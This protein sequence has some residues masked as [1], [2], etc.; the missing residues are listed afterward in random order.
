MLLVKA[1]KILLAPGLSL[2]ELDQAQEYMKSFLVGFEAVYP[3]KFL[4]TANSHNALHLRETILDHSA[5]P[6]HWLF[7]FERYNQDI[8]GFRTYRKGCNIPDSNKAHVKELFGSQKTI[9]HSSLL[10]I[11]DQAQRHFNFEDYNNVALGVGFA[12]GSECLHPNLLMSMTPS[13]FNLPENVVACLVGY[14]TSTYKTSYIDELLGNKFNSVEAST[15]I[16][17]D[18]MQWLYIKE[19]RLQA[20][21]TAKFNISFVTGYSS[22]KMVS[23]CQKPTLL[24]MLN[25]S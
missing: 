9:C 10:E 8:K 7:N 5:S 14:Y 20:I 22:T 1:S 21:D 23:T 13:T 25:G 2:S 6:S 19:S 3:N 16:N 11:Y 18:R 17:V 24:R 4:V 15:K 12:S